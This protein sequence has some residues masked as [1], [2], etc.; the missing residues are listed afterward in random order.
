M[1]SYESL[2]EQ[3]GDAEPDVK[4]KVLRYEMIPA[5]DAV[6]GVAAVL[7]K[8]DPKGDFPDNFSYFVDSLVKAGLRNILDALTD[9]RERV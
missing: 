6:R 5:I 1:S 8:I 4:L 7:K 3:F 2:R 9:S